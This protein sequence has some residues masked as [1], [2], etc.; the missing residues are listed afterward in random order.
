MIVRRAITYTVCSLA[1][2]SAPTA[3]Q[4]ALAELLTRAAEYHASFASRA[5]GVTLDEHYTFVQVT[6]GR[7]HTPMRFR[8]DVVVLDLNGRMISLRDPYLLDNVVLRER[9]PRIVDTLREPTVAGWDRAQKYAAESHFRFV[10]D[11]VLALND[12]VLALRFIS[13]KLQ[14][15]LTYKFEGLKKLDGQQVASIGF[16]EVGGRDAVFLLGTRGNA[17]ASGRFFVDPATGAIR[18]TELWANSATEAVVTTVT[19]APAADLGLW[20]PAK[21]TQTFEWKELDDVHSNRNVGAY[22]ARLFFQANATYKDPSHTP[23]DL[24]KMRR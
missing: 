2:L 22:G 3:E 17:A 12:P 19:Y 20:L 14:P 23:I 8:S 13:R 16:K 24:S 18:K 1:F 10:S 5:S 9:K 15:K 4:P 7:M 21:M 11:V 6:A